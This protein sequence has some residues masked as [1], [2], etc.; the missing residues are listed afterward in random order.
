VRRHGG[1]HGTG[2]SVQLVQQHLGAEFGLQ[3]RPLSDRGEPHGFG[4]VVVVDADDR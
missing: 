3:V 4:E 1:L 2:N